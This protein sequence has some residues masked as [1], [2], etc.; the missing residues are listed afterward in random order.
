[1]KEFAKVKWN[2]TDMKDFGYTEEEANNFLLNY[3]NDIEDAMVAAGWEVIEEKIKEEK[4]KLYC[5]GDKFLWINNEEYHLCC[6]D[7]SKVC[8]ISMTTFNRFLKPV[9]VNNPKK[10]TEDEFLKIS[11]SYPLQLIEKSKLREDY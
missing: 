6:V 3:E 9:I 8:L 4:R 5:V 2:A 1:M 7:N 10:I 11:G